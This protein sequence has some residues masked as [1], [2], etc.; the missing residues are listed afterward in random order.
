MTWRRRFPEA[1]W[2]SLSLA[3]GATLD[4][5]PPFLSCKSVTADRR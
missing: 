2:R 4:S 1:G 5:D 3:N